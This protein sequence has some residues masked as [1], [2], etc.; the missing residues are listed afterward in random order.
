MS[1][2]PAISVQ[3][4]TW[5]SAGVIDACV[6]A[7][8]AQDSRAFEVV[9]VDNASV[10]G[11]A[12]RVEAWRDRLPALTLKRER[13][14]HGFCGGQN[15]AIAASKAPWILF[16]NPDAVL[17]NDFI[18]RSIEVTAA[19]SRDV[20]SVA[21]CILLPDGAIDST[22]LAMDR[23]RRAYDRDRSG[24]PERQSLASTD[25]LG[26]TGAV[27]LLRRAMLDD[28]AVDGQVLDERIFAYYD[29][30]DL[31]WRAALRGWRCRY[32]PSLTAV[33]HRAGRNAIRALAGRPTRVRDQVLSVRNRLLVIARCDR[34]FDVVP[35]LLW[36]V[37]FEVLRMVY[38]GVRA[39]RVLRAYV[40]VLAELPAALSARQQIHGR[41]SGPPLPSLP[42]KVR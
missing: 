21:P 19:L 11:C 3:I 17:P 30:L 32:E 34:P 38:L 35:A 7:L 40:E 39:P 18:G 23:F 1:G 25:V 16:L 6:A 12:D 42:W 10:D 33:H 14:N 5:N 37:P 41:L 31:A 26:C 22:G 2:R 20:G 9:V 8:A 15:L 28:V 29:D 4:V 13:D 36:L 27:A 24:A